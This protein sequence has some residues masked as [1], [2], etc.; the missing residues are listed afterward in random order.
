MRINDRIDPTVS[1]RKSC[2]SA[3]CGS[4][5]MNINGFTKLA[6]NTQIIPEFEKHGDLLIEPLPNQGA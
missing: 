4:C 5:A 2:R 1:F 3:I 6:C